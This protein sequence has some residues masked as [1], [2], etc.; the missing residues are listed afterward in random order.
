MKIKDGLP[1]G[2]RTL[3]LPLKFGWKNVGNSKELIE[4]ILDVENVV[5]FAYSKGF[6]VVAKLSEV[7]FESRTLHPKIIYFTSNCYKVLK[8]WIFMHKNE[9]KVCFKKCTYYW[10]VCLS[11]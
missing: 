6:W 8:N 7:F 1:L 9:S 4:G 3:W 2:T 11:S 5:T 10:I